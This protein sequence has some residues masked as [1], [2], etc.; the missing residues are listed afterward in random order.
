MD[1]PDSIHESLRDSVGGVS[2]VETANP[3]SSPGSISAPSDFA[4]GALIANRFRIVR[5]L[6]RGGMGEVYEALDTVSSE[7]VA[8]KT[9]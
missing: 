7:Q 9:P 6:G 3:G 5:I 1:A 8:L 2:E 4:P